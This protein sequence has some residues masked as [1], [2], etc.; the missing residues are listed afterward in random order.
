MKFG[1][2]AVFGATLLFASMFG[3]TPASAQFWQCVPYA[4]MISGIDIHGNAGTWWDQA[5]GR[6]DRGHAPEVG[7]VM[8]LKPH[9]KMTIGHVAMVSGIVSDREITVTHANWSRPGGIEKDVRVVDVSPEGDWS[10]VKV[11]YAGVDDLGGTTYPTFGFI[12]PKSAPVQYADA[13]GG[14]GSRGAA[15]N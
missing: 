15:L 8:V 14:A 9:G 10:E 11:W 4:R 1:R 2:S 3:I 7:S 5:A 6:Y 13:S 12:Y